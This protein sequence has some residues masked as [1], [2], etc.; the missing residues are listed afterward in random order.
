MK[1]LKKKLD[2]ALT[3]DKFYLAH[4]RAKRH[5]NRRT[6]IT[7]FSVF[8][9]EK[10]LH[11]MDVIRDERYQP[12]KYR[13]FMINDPK[14]RLILA[15]PYWDRIVHQWYVEEFIKPYY[16]PRFIKDTYACIPGRGSHRAAIQLQKYMRDM[17]CKHPDGYYVLKMD[18]SKFFYNIDPDIMY[19]MLA[20][21]IA[22]PKLSRLTKT[23]IYD[24][25]EHDGIPIGNYISQY[26][27]NIYLNELDQFCKHQLRVKYYVRYMD[28]FVLLAQD[29]AQAREWFNQIE[30]FLADRLRLKLNPHSRY[31]PVHLGV[32]FAGY[33]IHNDYRLLRRRSKQKLID[34][35]DSYER[36]IDGKERFA[37]RVGSWSGH[38]RYADS[39]RYRQKMLAKYKEKI[40]AIALSGQLGKLDEARQRKATKN[41]TTNLRRYGYQ[42][43]IPK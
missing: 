26:F 27:A 33:R 43:R 15:L 5:K 39:F 28:D 10:L 1:S 11:I 41:R 9:T 30:K 14:R 2:S 29:K 21:V 36:G 23:M 40:P 6:E 13:K 31:Y 3:L 25:D 24:G 7:I 37:S 18:I 34:I 35:I 19:D 8:V 38:A 4:L 16:L 17:R 32:D 22:D 12:S 42:L 20:R